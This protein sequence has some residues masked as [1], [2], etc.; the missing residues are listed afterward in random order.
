MNARSSG[1]RG[2]QQEQQQQRQMQEAIQR[3]SSALQRAEEEMR[4][5]V[6]DHDATAEQRAAS[7][8]QQAQEMLRSMLHDQAGSS[9]SDLAQ[10]AQDIANQQRELAQRMKQMYGNGSQAYQNRNG[11]EQQAN[12]GDGSS[13][14]PE[15]NDPTSSRFGYGF[16]RRNWASLQQPSRTP[17]EQEKALAAQKEKL[18]TEL[19]QLEKQMQQ[20]ADSMNGTQPDASSKMRR[21]LSDAEQ[22][23]LA[24]RMQKEAEWMRQGYGDRNAGMEDSVTAGLDQLSEQL[25]N[26]QGALKSGAQAGK[27]GQN[28]K[29][30]EALSEL[31]DLREQLQ[32]Q[33]DQLQ[34]GDNSTQQGGQQSGQQNGSQGQQGQQ[35]SGSQ[36]GANGGWSATGGPG[37]QLDRRGVQDAIGQLN[38]LRTQ[39]DPHDRALGG[40]I[41]GAIWNL[42]HLTGAQAGLL[43]E[44]ISHDAVAS[45]ERL[46]VELGKRVAQAQAQGARTGAPEAAPEKYRDAVSEYFK[47]LSQP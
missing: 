16:R 34:R 12:T 44:R 38:W 36:R 32:K 15:M 24:L 27:N 35:Q 14:M 13:A 40:Y 6:S 1:S 43:D 41:D 26:L 45:L 30:A 17:T 7:D 3:A 18:G 22:K 25:R 39:V 42:H 47:K 46:E 5:A 9:V 4:K 21:A 2:S 31:H 19:Q 20:Q 28:D 37:D 11:Y 10:R 8:L 29:A 23:E 33:S